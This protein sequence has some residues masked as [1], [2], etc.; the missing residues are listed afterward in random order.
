MRLEQ[1]IRQLEENAADLEWPD[2]TIN[3][4]ATDGRR[5]PD[6]EPDR[7]QMI[8]LSGS[9]QKRG[10]VFRREP[11]ESETDFIERTKR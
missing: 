3:I 7:L 8:V 10:K 5:T 1:R 11:G 6:P 4:F 2:T 9:P